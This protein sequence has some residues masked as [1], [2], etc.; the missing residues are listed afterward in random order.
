MRVGFIS[1]FVSNFHI[2]AEF[3]K[4]INE[5]EI[6]NMASYGGLIYCSKTKLNVSLRDYR[7]ERNL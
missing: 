1:T 3:I 4:R 6:Q 7:T 5:A 2:Y